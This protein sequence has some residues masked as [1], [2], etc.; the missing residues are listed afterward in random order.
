MIGRWMPGRHASIVLTVATTLVACG[1]VEFDRVEGSYRYRGLA[2]AAEVQV[3]EDAASLAQPVEEVGTLRLREQ[4][5]TRDKP[6][7]EATTR[8]FKQ[9][10]ARYGCDA[11]V[12]VKTETTER[13]VTRTS[14]AMGADGKP[15]TAST[16]QT[17]YTHAMQARCVRTAAAP[18]G[19]QPRAADKATP[20]ATG[21][22]PGAEPPKPA[23]PAVA[24][25]SGAAQDPDATE[26]WQALAA[27]QRSYLAAWADRLRGPAPSAME[28]LDC[29]NELMAQVTGPAGLWRKTLPQQWFGCPAAPDSDQCKRL[30]SADAEFQAWDRFQ[31]QLLDQRGDAAKSWLKRNKARILGYL[32]RYVPQTPSMSHAQGTPFYHDHLRTP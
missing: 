24:S 6:D 26:V 5:V 25:A 17:L 3:V 2:S 14:K 27:Y 18:G 11:V 12:G 30:A 13:K 16:E 29:V 9:H 22:A 23:A 8:T 19:L 21:L 10:A 32:A 4:D 20:A 31:R 15:V 28:V 1:G 7:L